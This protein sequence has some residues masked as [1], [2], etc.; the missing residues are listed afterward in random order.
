MSISSSDEPSID[1]SKIGFNENSLTERYS[2]QRHKPENALRSTKKY[3]VKKY[4]PSIVCVKDL[5]KRRFPITKWLPKYNIK[6]NILRD[7]VGGLT[8]G[9]VSIPQGM[10]YSMMAGLPPVNGL[11]V[12]FFTALVYLIFGTARHLSI[13][14]KD[15]D[16][17]IHLS[18]VCSFIRHFKA[19]M[20]SSR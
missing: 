2:Y 6:E 11:Y 9:V 13:G 7:L 1:I 17:C 16:P 4:K 15:L 19:L 18:T 20:E 10:G 5:V 3:V 12:G 8:I 14:K